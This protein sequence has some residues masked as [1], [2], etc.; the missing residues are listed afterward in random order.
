MLEQIDFSLFMKKQTFKSFGRC[1]EIHERMN[2]LTIQFK[3]KFCIL[4]V[5]IHADKFE[6][7][8]LVELTFL[9]FCTL[10]YSKKQDNEQDPAKSSFDAQSLQDS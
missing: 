3:T 9:N 4:R 8:A 2:K 1:V 10:V 7:L 5:T 6:S